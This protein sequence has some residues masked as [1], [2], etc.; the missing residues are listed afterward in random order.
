MKPQG[1]GIYEPDKREIF[2][3]IYPDYICF[4]V[5][6]SIGHVSIWIMHERTVLVKMPYDIEIICS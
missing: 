4:I 5:R 2:K 3:C 1:I 6:L